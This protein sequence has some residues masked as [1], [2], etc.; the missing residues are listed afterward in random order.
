[1]VFIAGKN[2]HRRNIDKIYDADNNMKEFN[3][4][5]KQKQMF[6]ERIRK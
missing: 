2:R 4:V 5:S 6:G 3:K 1:M